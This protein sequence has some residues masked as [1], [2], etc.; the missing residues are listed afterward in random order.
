MIPPFM[1]SFVPLHVRQRLYVSDLSLQYFSTH[2]TSVAIMAPIAKQPINWKTFFLCF[3]IS[4]GQFVG[5]YESVIIGTT[6]QKKDFMVR[7]GLWDNDSN[8]TSRLGAVEGAIVGL[9]Q[10]RAVRSIDS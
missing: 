3:I 9:F 1:V 7:M 6:L 4:L 8:P 10:V 5:A 2:S